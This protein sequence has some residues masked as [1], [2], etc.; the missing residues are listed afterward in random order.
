MLVV[1]LALHSG[2]RHEDEARGSA[3]S[4]EKRGACHDDTTRSNNEQRASGD[5]QEGHE[6]TG[7]R[8][9]DPI[10]ERSPTT[11]APRKAAK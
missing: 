9:S 4:C 3:H 5:D 10:P 7:G 2:N 1:A 6:W 8:N 11:R